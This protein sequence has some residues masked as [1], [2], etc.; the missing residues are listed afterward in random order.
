MVDLAAVLEVEGHVLLGLLVGEASSS[1]EVEEVAAAED[2][3][4][5]AL[6]EEVQPEAVANLMVV[7]HLRRPQQFPELSLAAGLHREVHPEVSSLP[8]CRQALP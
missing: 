2:L 7:S 1:Q 6:V 5:V 8:S 4:L 3:R